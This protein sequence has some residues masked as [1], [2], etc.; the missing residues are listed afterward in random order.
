MGIGFCMVIIAIAFSFPLLGVFALVFLP[1][2]V[3][4]YRLKLGRNRAGI[5]VAVC[6]A[7]LVMVT[8]GMGFDM[9]YFGI[10][11]MT[12]LIAGE[13]IE[14]QM[15]IQ[16]TIVLT[17]AGILCVG[18]A[19]LTAIAAARGLGLGELFSDYT[20]RYFTM[21]GQLYSDMGIEK[22]QVDALNAFILY[23]MPGMFAVSFISTVWLNILIIIRMLKKRGL[24][25]QNLAHLNHYRAP[26]YLVWAVIVLGA[27]LFVPTDTLKYVSVNCLIVLMLVY[28]FQ[29][30]AIVSFF[31]Q[32]KGSPTHL[33]VFCYSL[34]AVQLYVL[35][36]VIGLGFFDNWINFRKLG[37]QK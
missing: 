34:I 26:E 3:L 31:F 6:V 23:I 25:L 5:M 16:Q 11:L 22:E 36:V 21:S 8:R 32:K 24:Y 28:F 1:L 18:L 19:G 17:A 10:L 13:C 7:V 37:T 12:G 27:L 30:I 2:P 33:R 29:G 35:L 9:L 20:V 4:F 15:G 14:R